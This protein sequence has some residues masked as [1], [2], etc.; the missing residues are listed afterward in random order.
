MY[1]IDHMMGWLFEWIPF[2]WTAKLLFLCACC[3]L[4]GATYIYSRLLKPYLASKEAQI[5]RGLGTGIQFVQTRIR[6]AAVEVAKGGSSQTT[7]FS[8]DVLRA[9]ERHPDEKVQEGDDFL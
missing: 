2:Y 3:Y 7:E 6:G 9:L 5:D 4:N 1:A 8:G